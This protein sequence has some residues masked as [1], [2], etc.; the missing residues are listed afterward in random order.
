G[1]LGTVSAPIDHSR[2]EIWV[3]SRD[4][5]SCDT[6]MAIPT[7]LESRLR[8]HQEVDQVQECLLNMSYWKKKTKAETS[9]TA[10]D[11]EETKMPGQE[12]MKQQF[13]FVVGCSLGKDPLGPVQELTDEER[14][15]LAETGTVVVP[16]S[17]GERAL[18]GVEKVGEIA[19]IGNYTVRVV[20]F[21][22]HLSGVTA[23][24]VLCSLPTA[25]LLLGYPS[26][27]TT[28]YLLS[29]HDPREVPQLVED[30]RTEADQLAEK[31]GAAKFQA[32]TA[33]GFAWKTKEY[34]IQNTK[35][36]VAIGILAGLGL[37][38]GILVTS[39]TLYSA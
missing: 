14:R 28:Y 22:H 24:Y 31:Q 4:T 30:L 23:P 35:A 3:T 26:D 20:G 1:L 2:A 29:C 39:Q 11:T 10:Q 19:Q 12:S 25:R 15:A 38:V 6:G 34:W 8:M 36:G 13:V 17:P 5:L 16:D 9:R 21:H 18:L 37:V 33:P 32:Y 27:F 7:S